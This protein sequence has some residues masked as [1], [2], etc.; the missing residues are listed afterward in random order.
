MKER[1]AL[2][3]FSC[4]CWASANFRSMPRFLASLLGDRGFSGA[5][6][7]F[8]TDLREADNQLGSLCRTEHAGSKN[9]GTHEC[10]L[11]FHDFLQKPP[12]RGTH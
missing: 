9:R 1:I 10:S 3:W 11:Q 7:G 6:A 2:I 8:R 5:P 4:F 12:P